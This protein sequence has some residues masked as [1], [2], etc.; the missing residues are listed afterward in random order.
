[1]KLLGLFGVGF[2]AGWVVRGSVDS[3][4][5]ALV[6]VATQWYVLGNLERLEPIAEEATLLARRIGNPTLLSLSA[7]Y[8]GAALEI[9]DPPRARSSF[10][11]A[12]ERGTA[13]ECI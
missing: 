4:R 9:A 8:L 1:M 11:T 12:I 7:M 2:A 6:S 3:S 13:G 10:E 5:S